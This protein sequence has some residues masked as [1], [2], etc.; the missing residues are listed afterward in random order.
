MEGLYRRLFHPCLP[1]WN[2]DMQVKRTLSAPAI[3]TQTQSQSLQACDSKSPYEHQL[4]VLEERFLKNQSQFSEKLNQIKSQKQQLSMM[5]ETILEC[6]QQASEIES[7]SLDLTLNLLPPQRNEQKITEPSFITSKRPNTCPGNGP[8]YAPNLHELMP[9]D[10]S[11]ASE[12]FDRSAVQNSTSPQIQPKNSGSKKSKKKKAPS[13]KQPTPSLKDTQQLGAEQDRDPALALES[14]QAEDA[15]LRGKLR[16]AKKINQAAAELE[17]SQ[18]KNGGHFYDQSDIIRLAEDG[19]P[20]AKA[21]LIPKKIKEAKSI[22]EET[23]SPSLLISPQAEVEKVFSKAE[24]IIS[25]IRKDL[26]KIQESSHIDVHGAQSILNK[27]P[28]EIKFKRLESLQRQLINEEAAYKKASKKSIDLPAARIKALK[29]ALEHIDINKEI[30]F[31]TKKASDDR[32]NSSMHLLAGIYLRGEFGKKANT[33]I[34]L[35][36]YRQAAKQGCIASQSTLWKLHSNFSHWT[37]KELRKLITGLELEANDGDF[38]AQTMLA[39]LHNRG[40]YKQ[41]QKVA[42]YLEKAASSNFFVAQYYL[43]KSYIDKSEAPI[44]RWA[45]WKTTDHQEKLVKKAEELL[46]DT[47]TKGCVES[48]HLLVGIH[49]IK[50][51]HSTEHKEIVDALKNEICATVGLRQEL[52]ELVN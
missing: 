47:S 36:Y 35:G 38:L 8:L 6:Q 16:R 15:I 44:S 30:D 42:H 45:F 14:S 11:G 49:E 51:K 20:L 10:R 48:K 4:D 39:E 5:K 31:H 41:P 32:H 43:A 46:H 3:L 52:L 34:A 24:R 40:E 9:I 27:L 12:G 29:K 1:S 21:L 7:R 26:E 2:S 37:P 33:E 17:R 25:E 18:A 50:S 28:L 23:L 22:F 19:N 13:L